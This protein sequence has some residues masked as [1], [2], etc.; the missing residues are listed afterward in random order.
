MVAL[1]ME[2]SGICGTN[3]GGGGLRRHASMNLHSLLAAT[4]HKTGETSTTED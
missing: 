1:I 4:Q 3:S 2:I